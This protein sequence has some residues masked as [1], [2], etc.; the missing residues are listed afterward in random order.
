MIRVHELELIFKLPA[1]LPNLPQSMS[2]LLT[3]WTLEHNGNIHSHGNMLNQNPELFR[4]SFISKDFNVHVSLNQIHL[5]LHVNLIDDQIN[6]F[7]HSFYNN[8]QSVIKEIKA[9]APQSQVR[10]ISKI[11]YPFKEIQE[12]SEFIKELHTGFLKF[13]PQGEL[14][15]FQLHTG[16]SDKN[17]IFRFRFQDYQMRQTNGQEN[18][19]MAELMKFPV[20]ENGIEVLFDLTHLPMVQGLESEVVNIFRL[21]S[22]NIDSIPLNFFN[23]LQSKLKS[24]GPTFN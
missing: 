4:L 8:Y 9:F 10:A 20:I 5:H 15:N 1:V 14:V 12:T 17:S 2:S 11:F 23:N 18:L 19:S 24:F 3:K 21:L 6:Q 13:P 22:L 16:Y 7:L